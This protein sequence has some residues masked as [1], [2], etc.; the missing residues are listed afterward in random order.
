MYM[1]CSG[2]DSIITFPVLMKNPSLLISYLES[3]MNDLR[4]KNLGSGVFEWVDLSAMI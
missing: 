4:N 2:F 1:Y 3:Y